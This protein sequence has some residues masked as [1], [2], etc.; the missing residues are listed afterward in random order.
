MSGVAFDQQDWRALD[1]SATDNGVVSRAVPLLNQ[2]D[3]RNVC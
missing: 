2:D 3:G 1:C